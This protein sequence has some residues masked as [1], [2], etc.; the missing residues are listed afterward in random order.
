LNLGSVETIGNGAFNGCTGL[1]GNLTIPSSVTN[2]DNYAFYNCSGFT[3]DAIINF[4]NDIATYIGEYAFCGG[5]SNVMQITSL[6][7]PYLTGPGSN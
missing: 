4:Q 7:F 2:I 3:G 5:T 6:V 1:S